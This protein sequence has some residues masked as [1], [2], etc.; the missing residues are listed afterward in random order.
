MDRQVAMLMLLGLLV[1]SLI[2]KDTYNLDLNYQSHEHIICFIQAVIL[3]LLAL[4]SV[5]PIFWSCTI[6]LCYTL[7]SIMLNESHEVHTGQENEN[8]FWTI[9]AVLFSTALFFA[10]DSPIAIGQWDPSLGFFSV[11]MAGYAMHVWDRNN[12][13]LEVGRLVRLKRGTATSSLNKLQD[14]GIPIE[15]QLNHLDECLRDIDQTFIPSTINNWINRANVFRKEREIIS[16]FEEAEPGSLNYLVCNS[17]LS[18]IFYKIKDHNFKHPH[19]TQIIEL[20]S[21]E[22]IAHLNV[23]SRVIL[24]HALQMLKLSANIKAEHCVRN[25]ILSTVQDDLSELKTLS[26]AKGDYLSFVKLVYDD[27]KSEIVRDEILKHIHNQAKVQKQHML[28]KTKRSRDRKRKFWRKVLSDVDDTL[29]CSGGSYPSGVDKRYGKKVVYPGV[30][31]FY[32]ELDLGIDGPPEWPDHTVGNLVFLSARP[33]VY[34]D[35]SE[36]MNFAKFKRLQ[37][38]GMHTSPSL[39]AGDINSGLETVLKNDFEPLGEIALYYTAYCV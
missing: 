3:L 18:L 13:R 21:I 26:D 2:F 31:G 24:L 4:I 34:K 33:H 11:L 14:L 7:F 38:K 20:L 27:I 29:T 6:S 32:R 10:V 5:A 12:H 8:R 1:V 28:F 19:R 23:Y 15:E 36:K 30:L 39:L 35:I 37:A 16:V 22:R 25:I 17:R 9:A